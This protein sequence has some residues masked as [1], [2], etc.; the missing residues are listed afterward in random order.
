MQKLILA[1]DTSNIETNISSN[2]LKEKEKKRRRL[3]AKKY[4]S[5]S[6]EEEDLHLY[7]ENNVTREKILPAFPQKQNF[8]SSDK[9]L[10]NTSRQLTRNILCENTSFNAENRNGD[11]YIITTY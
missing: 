8:V 5:S 6:S 10:Q 11:H 3:K 2:E 1:E 4:M 7:K 9:E